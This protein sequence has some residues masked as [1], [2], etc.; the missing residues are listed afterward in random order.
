MS[1]EFEFDVRQCRSSLRFEPIEPAGLAPRPDFWRVRVE[2]I[3]SE[4][5]RA[6]RGK[7]RV[8]ARTPAG[9]PVCAVFYG[10]FDDEPHQTNWSSGSAV[11][12]FDCFRPTG[13]PQTVLLLAG[14]HGAEAESV[15]ALVNLIHL[16]E[17]GRDFRGRRRPEWDIFLK[18]YRFIIVPCGNMDGRAI[19]PDHLKDVSYEEFRAA[20]QGRWLDGSLIG[21]G[22][23]GTKH[24]FPLP[25]DQV[26]YPGG[27][28][29]SAGYNIMHDAGP[30]KFYTAEAEALISLAARYSVDLVLNCHSFEFEPALMLPP[31]VNYRCN[32][33]RGLRCHSE[34]NAA[35]Q[36]A[37]LRSTPAASGGARPI[38]N[39]NNLFT[40]SSG[41]LALTFESALTLPTFDMLMDSTFVTV[42]T[43]LR[44]G[45]EEPFG[46]R[47]SRL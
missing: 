27:Y 38:V 9:Y 29:N 26:S 6:S 13:A 33:D 30:E 40:I 47:L 10:N 11:G 3:V 36:E 7:G 35:L 39:L 22:A 31:E 1:S 37:G 23:N 41:A 19:S 45:L 2:E 25:L 20:S 5:R 8:I 14:I 4:C 18:N 46:Y 24:Y 42:E 16:L 12:A 34:V 43:M 28:P 21:C 44:S 32:I 17:T 15:A